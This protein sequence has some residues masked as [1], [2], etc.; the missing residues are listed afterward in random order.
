[1]KRL[2]LILFAASMLLSQCS[3]VEKEE[4]PDPFDYGELVT[5][6]KFSISGETEA[7]G[8]Y[9]K[10]INNTVRMYVC[11]P[12]NV[13]VG[14]ATISKE[15]ALK[16]YD[17][18]ERNDTIFALTE[19]ESV[20]GDAFA[21]NG[22]Y[23]LAKESPRWEKDEKGIYKNLRKQMGVAKNSK[24]VQYRIKHNTETVNGVTYILPT[25]VEK[26]VDNKWVVMKMQVSEKN[27]LTNIFIAPDDMIFLTGVGGTFNSNNHFVKSASASAFV[28][29]TKDIDKTILTKSTDVKR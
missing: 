6:G 19:K 1:M 20:N 21:A 22:Q 18:M 7:T 15:L 4:L 3:K 28:I 8:V 16:A 24:G 10:N 14:N 17:L 11:T 5:W 27:Y 9:A 2:I 12:N 23:F 13:Y 26:F 25:E 29:K